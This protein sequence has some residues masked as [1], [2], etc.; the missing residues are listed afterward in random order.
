[1]WKRV[2]GEEGARRTLLIRFNAIARESR[3]IPIECGEGMD[4]RI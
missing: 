2:L 1:M 3:V 4:S